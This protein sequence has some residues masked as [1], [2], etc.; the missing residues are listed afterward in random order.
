MI[1]YRLK[2][3]AQSRGSRRECLCVKEQGSS[4]VW[5]NTICVISWNI[6]KDLPTGGQTR[7]PHDLEAEPGKGISQQ[8]QD[9]SK[10]NSNE[11]IIQWF[12]VRGKIINILPEE[13]WSK[14]INF[15]TKNLS[16]GAYFLKVNNRKGQ[17]YVF[18]LVVN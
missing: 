10:T 12:D 9:N 17:F 3:T 13:T 1:W 8:V 15:E 4:A 6:L 2:L 18:R 11:Y 16:P 14:S 7:G 5:N